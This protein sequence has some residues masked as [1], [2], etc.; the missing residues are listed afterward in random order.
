MNN[1]RELSGF[2]LIELLVVIAIIGILAS[3]ILPALHSARDKGTD[4][5]IQANLSQIRETAEIEYDRTYSYAAICSDPTVIQQLDAAVAAAGG[6]SIQVDTA[7]VV[8]TATCNQSVTG[9]AIEVPL[10]ANPASF[11][12]IDSQS[13]GQVN[14]ASAFSAADD[15][16]CN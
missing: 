14:P 2:T 4:A 10:V 3:V 15:Y 13:L 1:Y 11:F 7:G 8:D 9:Y 16:S 12:C 5:A 6:V